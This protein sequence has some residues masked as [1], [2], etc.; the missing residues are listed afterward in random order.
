M[1][2]S[3]VI[4]DI[5][6]KPAGVASAI[7]KRTLIILGALLLGETTINYIDRQVVSVLGPTLREEFGWSNLQFATVLNAFLITYM[8]AYSFAGWVLD[9]LG[10]RRGLTL[11][12]VWWSTAGALTALSRGLWSMS[13]FRSLLA[14]GEAGAWPSFAKAASTWVPR[15]ARALFIG[16]CNSGSSLGAL[17]ATPLVATI[18]LWTNWRMAFFVTGLIGFVWVVVFQL[19]MRSHPEF[20]QTDKGDLSLSRTPWFAF[21]AYRQTWA[22]FFCRFLADPLWYLFIF[23]IPGFLKDERGLDLAGIRFVGAVPFVFAD[24]SNFISGYVA[25]RMQKAG[26]SIN[27]TRK[28]L[29]AFSALLSPIGIFA[30]FTQSIFWTI[31]L[32][33]AAIF[34]WMFWSVSV[35]TLPGDYFSPAEVGSVYGIAGT[36]STAGTALATWGVGYILDLHYGYAPVFIGISLLMPIAMIVGFSLMGR[37]E[38][39]KRQYP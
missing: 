13:A 4:V 5:S 10:I 9:K 30:V 1:S 34:F 8:F 7:S 24:A 3:P 35:H 2:H 36:G 33:S 31:A 12:M 11:A 21:L 22:V 6:E 39:V 26:W 25:L 14:I 29:M 15:D 37:V 23:W 38:P 27:R 19:F 32:I 28:T 17:I 16:A 18:T 20:A